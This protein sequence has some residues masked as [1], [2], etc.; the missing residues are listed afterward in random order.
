M[1]TPSGIYKFGVSAPGFIDFAFELE[2]DAKLFERFDGS[3]QARTWVPP[4]VAPITDERAAGRWYGDYAQLGVL[5]VLSQRAVDEL[6]ELLGPCGEF[7][8][9]STAEREYSVYHCTIFA[10]VLDESLS[11]VRR[12]ESGKVMWVERFVFRPGCLEAAAF[13]I[14]QLPRSHT[15]VS[16]AVADQVLRSGLSGFGLELVWNAGPAA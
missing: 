3:P 15:F 13:R 11:T 12:F 5:P 7:L 1:S 14:P 6:G 2:E 16:A 9:L 4:A 10:D 8:P